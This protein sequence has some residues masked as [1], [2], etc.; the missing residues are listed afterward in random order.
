M[1]ANT[2]LHHNKKSFWTPARLALTLLVLS[3]IAAL[4]ISS[5][6][7]T[8]EKNGP[9]GVA[10]SGVRSNGTAA[11]VRSMPAAPAT[12]VTLPPSV[13]DAELR[14]V[15]GRTIKLS[16]YAGKVV[17][18]NL[19]ATW[20]VPCRVEIPELVKLHK[21]F[22]S[23]GVEMIGLSTEDPEASAEN[24]KNFVRTFQVDYRIGWATPEVAVT[25]MQGRDSIPQSFIISRDGR[26]LK[27]FVGFNPIY[28]PPQI[29]Q[30]LE[31]A[32]NDKGK[33]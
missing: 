3:L 10:S 16:D 1:P 6:N 2:P 30:A 32:L 20:C 11:P 8:D 14:S 12:L 13:R 28:T 9:A 15:N 29:R 17:L 33:V 18:V 21:E 24:V 22:Q 26:L 7:S 27:R 23:Q 4:G 5:C 19:W 25:L 31:D